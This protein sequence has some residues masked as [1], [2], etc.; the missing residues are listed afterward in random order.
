M[1]VSTRALPVLLLAGVSAGALM[2]TP[3]AQTPSGLRV[4]HLTGADAPLTAE[5]SVAIHPHNRDHIAVSA[6]QIGRPGA[7]RV[8][9]V[10]FLS[11]DGGATWHEQAAANPDARSQGDD[12]L[13]FDADGR[14]FH[15][16]ISF[17]GIRVA[18]PAR[19]VSGVFVRRSDDG[20]RHWH[21]PVAVVDHRNTVRPFEDKPWI[22]V[23]RSDDSPH[24]GSVYVAW[25]R[26]DEYGS[27]APDCRSEIHVSRSRDRGD[28]FAM[29]MRISDTQGDCLDDDGTVEG[30]VPAVGPGGEVYVAWAGPAGLVVDRSLD[31]GVT[32]GTDVP[33][34]DMPGGWDLPVDGLARSNGMP[35]TMVDLSRGPRRGTVYVNWI[36]LRHGDPDVFVASSADRGQTWR[37]PVRV[38]DDPRGTGAVQFFTWM[39]V[40]P[41]D[42]AVHVVF[43]DRRGH[44][45]TTT[46]VTL[47][48]SDDGGQTW[49]NRQVPIAP[50]ATRA[51]V[52]FGDYNGIDARDGRVVAAF[53]RAFGERQVGIS[54]VIAD[55]R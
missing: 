32:F 31:G 2:T 28:T 1:H 49:V 26:F 38:N 40:D 5:V 45:G 10:V 50:F 15:S 12:A 55:G 47:A 19:A 39:A 42:G 16:Y 8:T 36:D 17:L 24:R 53:P 33:I 14:L 22:T 27:R 20:G 25:T 3:R 37:A 18:D 48:R 9:N 30:A 4:V 21:A 43:H 46:G 52:A 23:D 54:V 7:P 35:V 41:S 11:T 13:A 44:T 29:P 6:Y 34:S 51:D